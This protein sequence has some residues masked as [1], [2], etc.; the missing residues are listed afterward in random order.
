M[1]RAEALRPPPMPHGPSL[2]SSHKPPAPDPAWRAVVLRSPEDLDAHAAEWSALEKASDARLFDSL[3]FVR[4]AWR[5]RPPEVVDLLAVLVTDGQR[6]V[7]AAP[8]CALAKRKAGVPLRTLVFLTAFEGD[9]PRILGE[10]GP[11]M[12]AFI[13]DSLSRLDRRWDR[14]QLDEQTR[15]DLANALP[16]RRFVLETHL[17]SRTNRTPVTGSFEA[18]RAGLPRRLRTKLRNLDSRIARQDLRPR[19]EIVAHPDR[20]HSCLEAFF[21]LEA[22]S[23][24]RGTEIAA[25]ASDARRRFHHDLVATFG[26]Q[27][28]AVFVFL[29]L[30]DRIAA[31]YVAL[32]WRRT[33]YVL[34]VAH[35]AAHDGVAPGIALR[36]ALF[37]ALWRDD[38]DTLDMLATPAP[39]P[40][41]DH[42]AHWCPDQTETHRLVATRRSLRTLPY[43]LGKAIKDRIAGR[44]GTDAGSDPTGDDG[45]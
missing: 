20:W 13:L 22:R 26:P 36:P 44:R 27:G 6:P 32:V 15:G 34:H 25:S 37:E 7:A 29:W 17:A 3:D 18:F 21:E 41:R 35:D 24:K 11:A 12:L 14:V 31:G 39:L 9:Q 19:I 43:R 2:G 4:L 42:K 23:W 1:P 40:S 28:R 5:H 45:P 30:E 38:V 8:F 16:P 10:S 33:A